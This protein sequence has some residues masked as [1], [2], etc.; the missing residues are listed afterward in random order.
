MDEKRNVLLESARIARGNVKPLTE[1]KASDYDALVVPGGF[2]VAKNLSD[3]AFK[4]DKM[5]V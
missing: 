2:G 1:L 5:T 4:G 3:Y